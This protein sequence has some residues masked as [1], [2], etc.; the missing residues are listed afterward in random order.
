M[1]S[2]CSK[3][4]KCK[5]CS[6]FTSVVTEAGLLQVSLYGKPEII[7]AGYVQVQYF[8]QVLGVLCLHGKMR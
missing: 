6:L 2:Q 4:L 3:I 8:V 1:N 5:K 7:G